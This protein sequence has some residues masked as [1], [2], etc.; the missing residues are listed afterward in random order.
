MKKIA[1]VTNG[2]KPVPDIQGGAVEHL[3]TTLILQNETFSKYQIDAY[4]LANKALDAY[5]L[6]NCNIIQIKNLQK[7]LP[8][9]AYFSIWNRLL[10]L[11]KKPKHVD[12]M[13]VEMPR[14]VKEGYD[15]I[16]V[17][18]SVNIAVS[19]HEKYKDANVV[20][21][22]HNDYDVID[23]DY[24]KT[25]QNI[26][27]AADKGIKFITASNYLYDHL[28]ELSSNIIAYPLQN[29]I[30]K[31][32]FSPDKFQAGLDSLKA[33]YFEL[34]DFVVLFCG[35]ISPEKGL[36]QLLEAF[37]RI[38]P[39]K[40]IKLLVIGENWFSSKIEN[41]YERQISKLQEKLNGRLRN[42]GY[43]EQE[44]MPQYYSI[45]DLV[46][47]PTQC[48]E[49]FG[50]VALEAISMKKPCI[51][52]RCG[53]L[54]EII[55]DNCGKLVELDENYVENLAAEIIKFYD[56][57]KYYQRCSEGALAKA[58]KFSDETDYFKNFEKILDQIC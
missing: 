20:L 37:E 6:I 18:N 52:S 14:R 40:N 50:M 3:T 56:D 23:Y 49:A 54:T 13:M 31:R 7:I 26:L 16:I 29:C 58:E 27:R 32:L 21:H 22:L 15:C 36:L 19:I 1:F 11:M 5:Q 34:N 45:S 39:E 42:V 9:R 25:K 41:D 33:R 48:V 53:G 2:V 46:V 55:N 30:N 38:P 24:D 10:E 8:I 28:Q 44:D 35:R 57:R 47:V 51:A 12:Y 4:S 43:I 17:E